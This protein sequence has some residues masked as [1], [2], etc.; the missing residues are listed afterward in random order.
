MP[1]GTIAL[2]NSSQ[3]S[4]GGY[5]AGTVDWEYTQ[6]KTANTSRVVCNLFLRKQISGGSAVTT[7]T[8]GNWECSL[9]VNGQTVSGSVY[10][11]IAGDWVLMLSQIIT[12]PPPYC[13]FGIVPSKVL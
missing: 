1:S 4:G 7:A 13:P 3:T 11:G 10:A 9:T 12:V 8:T 2:Q 6:D 5:I